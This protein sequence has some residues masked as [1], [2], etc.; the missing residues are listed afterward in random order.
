MNAWETDLPANAVVLLSREL[1]EPYDRL[2]YGL[3]NRAGNAPGAPVP[4]EASF[5]FCDRPFRGLYLAYNGDAVL[6]CSDWNF[7]AALGNVVDDGL[8]AIWQGEAY[9]RTRRAL[10]AGRREGLCARCDFAGVST[11][12]PAV[13]RKK[14]GP[15]WRSLSRRVAP[16]G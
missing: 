10:L 4:A 11:S 8:L 7:E 1:Q 9:R 5:G 13:V 12:W 3:N 2:G 6:C 15:L 16:S 14:A